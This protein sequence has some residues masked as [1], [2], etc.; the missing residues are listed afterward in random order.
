MSKKILE[1]FWI[2]GA[3]TIGIV[4]IKND[5]DEIK[6]YIGKGQGL[7]SDIDI[8]RIIDYGAKVNPDTVKQFFERNLN[9]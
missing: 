7:D 8:Q 2:S 1:T 4:A 9:K 6:F 5:M 3:E